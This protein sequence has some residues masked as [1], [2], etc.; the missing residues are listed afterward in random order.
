MERIELGRGCCLTLYASNHFGTKSSL[1]GR[2]SKGTEGEGD[3]RKGRLASKPLFLSFR[4]RFALLVFPSLSLSP[5][6]TCHAG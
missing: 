4:P 2:R 3:A 6:N 1:R 5:L